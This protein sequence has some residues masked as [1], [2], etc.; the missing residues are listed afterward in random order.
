MQLSVA[1]SVYILSSKRPNQLQV[2]YIRTLGN[3]QGNFPTEGAIIKCISNFFSGNSKAF[4]T[5]AKKLALENYVLRY[6]AAD[7]DHFNFL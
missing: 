2:L 6:P 4:R 5:T 1:V 7:K 3:I